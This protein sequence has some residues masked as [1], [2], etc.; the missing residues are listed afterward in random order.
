MVSSEWKGGVG[1]NW[2][3]WDVIQLTRAAGVII[4]A[5]G[6]FLSGWQAFDRPEGFPAEESWKA[7]LQSTLSYAWQG[8]MLIIVA[9]IA[10]RL[11]WFS[12]EE[13]EETY[14]D[15]AAATGEELDR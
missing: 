5:L 1:M 12:S 4:I 9:E 7:F 2:Q 10:L 8:A 13:E 15:A 14:E 3:K 6:I 11:G